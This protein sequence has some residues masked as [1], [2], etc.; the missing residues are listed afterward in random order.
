VIDV[1]W[2]L[3]TVA[4]TIAAAAIRECRVDR[5]IDEGLEEAVA[6]RSRMVGVTRIVGAAAAQADHGEHRSQLH[7]LIVCCRRG[8]LAG[9]SRNFTPTLGA[10]WQPGG[11]LTA[12]AR[13]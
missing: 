12:T 2:N 5:E 13:A 1:I 10:Y 3:R 11:D 6:M 9:N 4:R 8:W 7:A